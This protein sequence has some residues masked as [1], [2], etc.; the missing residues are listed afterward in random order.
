MWVCPLRGTDKYMITAILKHSKV[1]FSES[2]WSRT[3]CNWLVSTLEAGPGY[4]A[5]LSPKLLI[6]V[7]LHLGSAQLGGNSLIYFPGP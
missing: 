5:L 1:S 2:L 6:K 4:R 3:K 7:S